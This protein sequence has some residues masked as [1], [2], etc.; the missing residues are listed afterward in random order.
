[1]LAKVSHDFLAH[2]TIA[3]DDLAQ[4]WFPAARMVLR[5]VVSGQLHGV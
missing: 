2:G 1:M 5:G 3:G 4:D